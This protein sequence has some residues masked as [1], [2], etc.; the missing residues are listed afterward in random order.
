MHDTP[1]A[2]LDSDVVVTMLADDTAVRAVWLDS[3]LAQRLPRGAIHLNMATVSMRIAREL[4]Q[5]MESLTSRR[6]CS[7]ARR[8]PRKGNSISSR[9]ARKR[10]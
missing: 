5:Y 3:G 10:A 1:Q 8:S 7:A 2:V 6:R 4:L 9:P